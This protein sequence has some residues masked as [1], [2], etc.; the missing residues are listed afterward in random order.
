MSH[1]NECDACGAL[2]AD[3]P[4]AVHIDTI[5]VATGTD[6]ASDSWSELDF[7]INCSERLLAVIKPALLDLDKPKP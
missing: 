4:G 2:F 1:A 6:G 5:H 7:C 3:A